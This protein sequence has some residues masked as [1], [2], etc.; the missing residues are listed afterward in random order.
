MVVGLVRPSL[1]DLMPL[2]VCKFLLPTTSDPQGVY[3]YWPF[4]KLD[5][6]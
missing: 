2:L 1:N 3:K 5:D 4:S 6:L